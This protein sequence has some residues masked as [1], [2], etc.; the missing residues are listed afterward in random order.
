MSALRNFYDSRTVPKSGTRN[1]VTTITGIIIL[2]FQIL[3]S[4]G[5]LSPEQSQSLGEYLTTL[6][7]A[8]QT[9]VTVITAVILM[10]KANDA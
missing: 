7:G 3:V 5:V 4:F 10:F 8:I 2:L 6:S 1:L 9:I